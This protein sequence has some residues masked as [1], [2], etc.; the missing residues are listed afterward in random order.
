M[1][2]LRDGYDE[3][4]SGLHIQLLYLQVDKE[5]LQKQMLRWFYESGTPQLEVSTSGQNDRVQVRL[6]LKSKTGQQAKEKLQYDQGMKGSARF[7]VLFG[8][9][10]NTMKMCGVID[11]LSCRTLAWSS[12]DFWS[13]IRKR[14]P[15]KLGVSQSSHR[16][17]KLEIF[18]GHCNKRGR[19]VS[20]ASHK[21]IETDL[22][23]ISLQ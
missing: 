15:R 9:Q 17:L 21:L 3:S 13:G 10:Q 20:Q 11:N 18:L 8:D 4:C 2:I 12:L 19:R 22:L 7:Q 23:H 16:V 14:N 5:A 6:N 1:Y